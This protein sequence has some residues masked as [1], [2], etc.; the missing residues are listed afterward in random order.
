MKLTLNSSNNPHN[1]EIIFEANALSH[2]L[3]YAKNYSRVVLIADKKVFE[4]WKNSLT[5]ILSDNSQVLLVDGLDQ[6]KTLGTYENLLKQ[7][8]ESGCDR[9]TL[10]VSFGGGVVSDLAGF[11]ASNYMRGIDWLAI[12]TTLASQTDAAIGG[13]TGVN[14]DHY[15]NM[16]GSFWPPIAVLTDPGFLKTLDKRELVSGLGEIIKMGFICDKNILKLIDHLDPANLLGD[17]LDQVSAL[18]A[19]AKIDIVNSDMYEVGQRKILNFGHS[20]G[21]A[22]ESISLQTDNPLLH[23]EA[24]AIGMVAE[25][26]L[27]ELEDVCESGLVEAVV[28]TLN[29]FVLP[30]QVSGVNPKEITELIQSD[31]KN[32]N[33]KILWTLPTG[34][35]QGIFGHEAKPEN[36]KKA[37]DFILK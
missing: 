33:Q 21:H 3:L 26:R 19:R 22:V 14:L 25:T 37:V 2:L 6:H 30:A 15:K 4:L 18:S 28:S 7:M 12:P 23:G 13:K 5:K 17:K 16:V 32:R 29:R 9:Q 10:V 20:V 1:S 31:K 11:V 27:A 24:V 35:G 8:L 34:V 36:I